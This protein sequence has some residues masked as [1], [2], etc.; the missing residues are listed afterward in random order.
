MNY[1]K[2]HAK[3]LAIKFNKRTTRKQIQK[4][5]SLLQQADAV[6][7]QLVCS[8]T[9]L[10]A[11][12]LRKRNDFFLA[13]SLMTDLLSDAYL[14]IV[15]ACECFDFR[16]GFKF[17]TYCTWVLMNNFSRDISG[18][19]KFNE[20]FVTGVDESVYDKLDISDDTERNCLE[21]KELTSIN[22]NRLLGLL[23]REEDVRKRYVIEQWFG[24][25]NG[26]KRTLNN[27]PQHLNFTQNRTLQH[28]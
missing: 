16:R 15:K 13:H 8:N 12:I 27:I 14:N 23:D 21:N 25:K 9:R 19:R 11:Q 4:V 24:L 5:E 20:K 22:I 18:E 1:Y 2:Y 10:S 3:E 6:K 17:S 26:G 7:H 28:P